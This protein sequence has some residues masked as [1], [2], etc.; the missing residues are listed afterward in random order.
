MS[1][2][3]GADTG[4]ELGELHL[5]S[6]IGRGLLCR[7]DEG[8]LVLATHRAG[9]DLSEPVV[10]GVLVSRIPAERAELVQVQHARHCG[11]LRG[12]DEEV[13]SAGRP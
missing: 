4:E 6:S 9:V 8:G 2:L 5:T 13:R 7:P 10:T 11:R 12:A 3:A 1:F